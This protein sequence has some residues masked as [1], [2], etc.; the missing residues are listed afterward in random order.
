MKIGLVWQID[1]GKLRR[2]LPAFKQIGGSVTAGNSSSIRP[3]LILHIVFV[4][5]IPPP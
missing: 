4:Y 5:Y 1:A 3:A 2:L